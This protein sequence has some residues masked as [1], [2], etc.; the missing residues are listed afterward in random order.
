MKRVGVI[1]NLRRPP[2]T[3]VLQRLARK[4]AALGMQLFCS[5]EASRYLEG[6][7]EL[8]LD[9]LP[10]QIDVLLALGG[11]GT[12]L[13]AVRLLDGSDTPVLGVNLGSLG[14]M[15]SLTMEELERALDVLHEGNYTRSS[16]AIASCRLT[17]ED[18]LVGDY[19]GL[20][21]IVISWGASSRVVTLSLEIDGQEVTSYVCDGL[22]I[23]TP[24]GSTGHSLSA[25]GPILH[26]ETR[27]FVISV[28]CPHALSHRPL[29]IP[30]SCAIAV[31]V[32]ETVKDLILA[33]DGQEEETLLE[34]DKLEV[35]RSPQSVQFIHL[36]DY[37]YYSVLRHKLGWKGSSI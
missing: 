13:R 17:R 37:S 5:R 22:I 11:D 25:G 27:A 8:D 6:A 28:I 21:D 3:T 34:G 23:S 32:S 2:A 7:G 20:N 19:R 30:D 29:V 26:P 16:R 31:K 36:P 15:T 33:V 18:K 14:F 35:T 4:A 1:V 10:G 24:T 9:A 12:M